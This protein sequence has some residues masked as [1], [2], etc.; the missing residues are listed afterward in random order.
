MT[1]RAR[2][3]RTLIRHHRR[4]RRF[5]LVEVTAPAANRTHERSP[6]NLSFV[7]DRSGS[8]GGHKIRLAHRAVEE[9]IRRLDS[10]DRL[11]VIAYDD[12]VEVVVG[13]TPASAEAKRNAL[14]RLAAIDARGSTNLA[15]GWLRGCEQ[16]AAHSAPDQVDRCL[17]VTDGLANVGIT[18]QAELERHAAEIAQRGIT[19]S[20]FGIGVDFDEQ[21]LGAIATN[22][23]GNFR[24]IEQAV[25]IPDFITSE[26]G[27]TL[28]VVA[29]DVTL[30]IE[31]EPGVIVEAVGPFKSHGVAG[32]TVVELGDMVSEQHLDLV[33]RF[34]FPAGE[35]GRSTSVRLVLRDR[36]GVLSTAPVDAVWHYSDDA[37][38][39][40]QPRDVSVDRAVAGRFAA[41]A[42]QAAVALNKSGRFAQ[43]SEELAG[44]GRRIRQYAGTD[45]ELNALADELEHQTLDYAAPMPAQALK[46]AHFASMNVSRGRDA[47]GSARRAR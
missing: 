12:R 47:M 8:M 44:V 18:D 19:T 4:S 7:L 35:R 31:T 46:Q 36:D 23:R 28:D 17:L 21:L 24:F 22:G 34:V 29:R 11:S 26:V 9:G 5:M 15:E 45:A 2:P 27:E 43:A 13:S 1:L 20:T 30:E 16:V 38:C 10:R 42:R 37:A 6:V 14:A 25:Q 40:A 33:L 3:D 32:R 39:D 41:R